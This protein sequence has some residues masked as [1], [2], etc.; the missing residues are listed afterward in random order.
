MIMAVNPTRME[1]LRLRK[2]LMLARRGH[3]LLRDKQDELLRHFLSLIKRWKDAR[4]G[5]EN[6][7][8]Q[9]FGLFLRAFLVIPGYVLYESCIRPGVET[10]LSCSSR[11]ITSVR[12][13]QFSIEVKGDPIAYGFVNTTFS[14]DK[15]ILSYL[16]L[17]QD[18]IKLAELEK[19]VILLADE[20]KKTRRRVNALE[21]VLIPNLEETIKY[22]FMKL[23]EFER[24]NLVRLM[25]VKEIVRAH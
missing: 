6:G 15:A 3:K 4:E 9:G 7:L 14:L 13:P 16:N 23:E 20:I 11:Q 18:L 10:V 22:I 2:R 21:Y 12:L 24:G 25:K 17:F 8:V 5:V 19:A 1:L